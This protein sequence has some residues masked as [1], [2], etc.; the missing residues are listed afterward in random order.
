MI[1]ALA[2]LNFHI[3][4]FD[5]NTTKIIR[6][7]E[8]A[9]NKG[10]DLIV[11][12]ELAV[13]G[14]PPRDFLEFDDFID[15]CEKA[16]HDIAKHCNNTAAII[17]APVKNTA[18]KGKRL[19][20]TACFLSDGG[21]KKIIKKALLPT[22]D[23]FDEYRY[24]E[25]G[26]DFSVIEYQGSKLAVTICEDLWGLGD[27]P[28]YAIN[29][30]DKL[31]DR[32]PDMI[33]NIAA[34]PFDYTR[35]RKRREILRANAQKYSLP[36]VYVN[37]TGAQTEL[38]FDGG[39]MVVDQNGAVQQ[40]LPFFEEKTELFNTVDK[41]PQTFSQKKPAPPKMEIL[42]QALVL[43]VE[44]YFRKS[45]FKKAI[46][47]LSGGIDSALTLVL[48][49]KAL[50]PRNVMSLIMP[51]RFSSDH[52]VNDAVELANTLGS[53]FEIISIENIYQ[54]YEESLKPHFQNLPFN[55]AEENIQARARAVLLMAFSNKFG[56][57]LLNTSNKS[58]AAVGY[59][60]LYGDMCGGLSVTGDLYKTELYELAGYINNKETLI[61]QN[62]INKPP[63]AELRAEQKD[64]DSLPAYPVLDEIL[65]RYIEQQ[66]SPG[67]I[68]AAG[69]D[70]K[71]VKKILRMVNSSEH[72]RFQA[73]PV[74]RIS[75]R[76]FG[77]G[78]RM[79]I[80][81]KYLI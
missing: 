81:G 38:I 76:A 59:G 68:I 30:M 46:L 39:S 4:N 1:I 60:T 23:I 3:G 7:I 28:M 22:Y 56:H 19:Y 45:G 8:E 71:L 20:N 17:G 55:T 2:Q 26:Q 42:L 65:V 5:Q 9:D 49:T 79:P 21:I 32:H 6:A 15:Q 57:I 47:G 37:H 41:T 29:P 36:V 70:K 75:P 12:P 33:I 74:L 10:A 72:K 67:D 69:Y 51:S 11:F 63:S 34:S 18:A 77:M 73:P 27:N 58:E 14:Y 24:F 61:P 48:A 64:T 54:A 53:P 62:I 43:G 16:L 13:S 35:Q 80:V 44:D 31:I 25:P 50:G 66:Q 78:R 40:Q 52:S